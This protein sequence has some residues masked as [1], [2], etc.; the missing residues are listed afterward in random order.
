[1]TEPPVSKTPAPDP[2]A[3][4][5][6]VAVERVVRGSLVIDAYTAYHKELFSF[7]WAATH[8]RDAAE[9]LLQDLF[10]RLVREER[11]GRAPEAVRPWLYRVASNLVIDRGRRMA[12]GRRWLERLLSPGQSEPADARLMRHED[13]ASVERA[14]EHVP[15][16]A[17]VALLM[18]GS[19][20]S[21]EEI[22][23]AIGRSHGATRSLMSRARMT[24]RHELAAEGV[25]S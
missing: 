15:P 18:S 4:P 17:R 3:E 23:V 13:A 11:S 16:V 1:M 10:L 6:V 22:A 25:T 20:F 8:D 21:G 9:D 14:L 12:T 19:G 24:I 2:L 7:L 5:R